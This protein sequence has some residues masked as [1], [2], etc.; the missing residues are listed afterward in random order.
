MTAATHLQWAIA[1]SPRNRF[2]PQYIWMNKPVVFVTQE[3]F[4]P[5]SWNNFN[6]FLSTF[7]THWQ[8]K[9]E[10]NQDLSY[11]SNFNNSEIRFLTMK[12]SVCLDENHWIKMKKNQPKNYMPGTSTS[13]LTAPVVT[14]EGGELLSCWRRCRPSSRLPETTPKL[15]AM[16]LVFQIWT[17]TTDKLHHLKICE[18]CFILLHTH[19]SMSF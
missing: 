17:N 3:I 19:L 8:K 18:F 4:S 12:F 1:L 7:I 13:R 14:S 11:E 16:L 15:N 9:A 5:R 10:I 2:P 6:L